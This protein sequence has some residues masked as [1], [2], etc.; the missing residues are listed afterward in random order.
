MHTTWFCCQIFFD[1]FW[2]LLHCTHLSVGRCDDFY[3]FSFFIVAAFI[4]KEG[5]QITT[6]HTHTSCFYSLSIPI[7]W[8]VM[9]KN[10]SLRFSASSLFPLLDDSQLS[11]FIYGIVIINVLLLNWLAKQYTTLEC[12]WVRTAFNLALLLAI[13]SSS[14]GYLCIIRI[15]FYLLPSGVRN[16]SIGYL[17]CF[18]NFNIFSIA[19]WDIFYCLVQSSKVSLL[20][21]GLIQFSMMVALW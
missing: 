21:Q 7:M 5:M 2:L 4:T 6:P 14:F 9:M 13:S 11:R 3:L 15:V 20:F 12:Q 17:Y 1:L 8:E 18:K 10:N 16:H 19:T